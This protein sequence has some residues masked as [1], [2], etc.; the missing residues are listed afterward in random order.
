MSLLESNLVFACGNSH[1][2]TRGRVE[3]RKMDTQHTSS[4]KSISKHKLTVYDPSSKKVV[5]L[6]LVKLAA[7]LA[8][9]YASQEVVKQS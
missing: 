1:V 2:G 9:I 8:Q 7:L 4:G 5:W 6:E 3:A